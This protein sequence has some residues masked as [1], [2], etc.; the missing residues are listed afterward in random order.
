MKD[1]NFYQLKQWMQKADDDLRFAKVSLEETDFYAHICYLAEQA[2]E[3][4]LKAVIIKH[5]GKLEKD[6]RTHNLIY[7]SEQNKKYGVNL[8]D[9]EADLRWLSEIYIPTRYPVHFEIGFEK[10][11]AEEAIGK[12]GEIIAFIRDKIL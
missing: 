3:K 2:V 1:N 5:K 10:K 12:A 4:Y 9:F 8:K 11:D 7:L 6:D